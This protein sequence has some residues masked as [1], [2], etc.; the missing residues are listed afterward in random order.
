MT[1]PASR[2]AVLRCS[3]LLGYTVVGSCVLW[4]SPSCG[5]VCVV[6]F[7]SF[8]CVLYQFVNHMM[9][10]ANHVLMPGG[11]CESSSSYASYMSALYAGVVA[12]SSRPW[13]T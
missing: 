12:V 8:G 9:V 7:P 13:C 6:V 1:C 10:V 3:L 5:G 2:S 11:S 4:G